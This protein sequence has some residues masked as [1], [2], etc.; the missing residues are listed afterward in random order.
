MMRFCLMSMATGRARSTGLSW[1]PPGPKA[2]S[3]P[4]ITSPTPQSLTASSTARM[5]SAPRLPAGTF[6]KITASY[7]INCPSESGSDSSPI[8]FTSMPWRRS[9][10]ARLS[11]C[12]GS[13]SA[14]STRERPRTT[15]K[16][17]ALLFAYRVSPS[18]SMVASYE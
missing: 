1:Y 11:A 5:P 12:V 3:P 15:V 7:G 8:T 2:F 9:T 17:A 4:I 10:E 14:K 13:L 6:D 16:P 18:V